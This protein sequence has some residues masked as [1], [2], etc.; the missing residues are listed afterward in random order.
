MIV[1]CGV[2]VITTSTTFSNPANEAMLALILCSSAFCLWQGWLDSGKLSFHVAASTAMCLAALAHPSTFFMLLFIIAFGF[3]SDRKKTQIVFT[4]LIPAGIALLISSFA[5]FFQSNSNNSATANQLSSLLGSKNHAL[6]FFIMHNG[7]VSTVYVICSLTWLFGLIGLGLQRR[8]FLLATC[9]LAYPAMVMV[10]SIYYA[11]GESALVLEKGLLPLALI[12]LAPY[13]IFSELGR[14]WMTIVASL[15]VLGIVVNMRFNDISFRMRH[16]AKRYGLYSQLTSER[17][18][19]LV[20]ANS[21][22]RQDFGVTWSSGAESLLYLTAISGNGNSATV[23]ILDEEMI[24]TLDL[25]DQKSF[26][27]KDDGTSISSSSLNPDY[28]RL[29]DGPYEIID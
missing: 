23:Q 19:V 11:D 9:A 21:N 14:N 7:Q 16:H 6:E 28:F 4:K 10:S 8:W 26:F 15:A 5:L 27:P 1:M 2:L 29:V 22:V 18:K 12:A 13:M 17:N 3:L 25:T 20:K 24:N